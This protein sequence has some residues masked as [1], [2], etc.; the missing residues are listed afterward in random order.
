MP[1]SLST[2]TRYSLIG[3]IGLLLGPLQLHAQRLERADARNRDM[4]EVSPYEVRTMVARGV[5]LGALV[6]VSMAY[7]GTRVNSRSAGADSFLFTP[8]VGTV[9]GLA[10]GFG[11][12][13]AVGV[14]YAFEEAGQGSLPVELGLDLAA[15]ALA[16]TATIASRNASPLIIMIPLDVALATIVEVNTRRRGP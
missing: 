10:L 8:T 2:V 11:I 6:G 1:R 4:D 9:W 3:V 15:S 5:T 16:A 7:F 14:H 13:S 12:G